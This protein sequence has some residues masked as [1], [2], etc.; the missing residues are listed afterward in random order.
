MITGFRKSWLL[1]MLTAVLSL[2]IA[3]T[4]W[5]GPRG[6]GGGCGMGSDMGMGPGMGHGCG[7]GMGHG[8]GKGCM[9]MTPEQAGEQFAKFMK[10][11]QEESARQ[12]GKKN[13]DRDEE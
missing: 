10:G 6:M 13:R 5:A 3:A 1:L 4:A 9:Q 12:S 2:G 7:M 8:G 11:V